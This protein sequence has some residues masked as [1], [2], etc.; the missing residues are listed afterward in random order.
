[1]TPHTTT[2]VSSTIYSRGNILAINKT[3][4]LKGGEL[5]AVIPLCH[6]SYET[7]LTLL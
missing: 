2:Y 6:L 1:M 7:E 4:K 3:I 5:P